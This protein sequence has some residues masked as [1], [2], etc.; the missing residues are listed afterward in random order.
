MKQYVNPKCNQAFLKANLA[1][2]IRVDGRHAQ[3]YR[4]LNLAFGP[5]Y[6]CC[7]A[8]LGNTKIL[9]QISASIGEPRL[10]RP[11]EGIVEIRVDL[12]PMAS[13][14]FE[15]SWSSEEHVEIAQLLDK[16][17]KEARCLDLESLCLISGEKVWHIH[18]DLTVINQEG[19]IIEAASVAA[20]TALAHHRRPD[21][22]IEDGQVVIHSFEDKNP[23]QFTILHRPFLTKF[24][25]FDNGNI[26]LCDPIEEEEKTCD[27]YL[28][29]GANTYREITLTNISGKSMV[30]KEKILSQY[31]LALKR[32][33]QIN[34]IVKK[35][36]ELDKSE[37]NRAY[38]L[39]QPYSGTI[40][41]ALATCYK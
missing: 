12:S 10:T 28:I 20:I 23:L 7:L 35:A 4:E 15:F 40:F 2:N 19:N 41:T 5:D 6:G 30:S 31:S 37:R 24:V 22:T 16:G 26:T 13:P 25:F 8:S 38:E 3:D 21:V 17:I 32:T 33:N 11:S 36:L 18:I 27:G 39:R 34:D 1:N 29:I 14:L 9:A